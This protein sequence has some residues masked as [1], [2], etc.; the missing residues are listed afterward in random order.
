M[1]LVKGSTDCILKSHHIVK[2]QRIFL[3]ISKL[4]EKKDPGEKMKQK[5]E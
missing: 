3:R 4:F 1:H 2:L 5:K